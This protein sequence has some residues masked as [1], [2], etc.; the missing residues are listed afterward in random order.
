M[1]TTGPANGSRTGKPSPL[2]VKLAE[3]EA[4]LAA[5]EAALK[6][7][8]AKAESANS[9]HAPGYKAYAT[10]EI[11]PAIKQFMVWLNREFPEQFPTTTDETQTRIVNLAIR[12][13]GYYQKSDICYKST[14]K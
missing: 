8:V 3:V 2:E 14:K 13:Y 1:T 9:A 7:A 4:K 10:K 6:E 5:T 11:A 12:T